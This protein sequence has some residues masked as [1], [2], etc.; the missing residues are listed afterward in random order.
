ML[1]RTRPGACIAAAIPATGGGFDPGT[2]AGGTGMPR[3]WNSQGWNSQGWN[4]CE[5]GADIPRQPR[6][7]PKP[8]RRGEP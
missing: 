4:F 5:M 3:G 6:K 8:N 7:S 2:W 1:T